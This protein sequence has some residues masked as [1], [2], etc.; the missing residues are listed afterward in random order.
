MA[1]TT[2]ILPTEFRKSGDNTLVNYDFVDIAGQT[3]IISFYGGREASGAAITTNYVLSNVAYYSRPFLTSGTTTQA[4]Y[5]LVS[6]LNFDVRL[7]KAMTVKGKCNINIPW[8]GQGGSTSWDGYVAC[9]L[10]KISGSVN[11]LLGAASGAAVAGASTAEEKYIDA[12]L[13]DLSQTVFKKDDIIRLN[14]TNY[15]RANGG[16]TATMIIAHDPKNRSQAT[17]TAD[18]GITPTILTLQLPVR[19]DL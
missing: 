5:T 6:N 19:I 11:T 17:G 10:R 4:N 18:W 12:F 14:V 3:G 8:S 13:L 15:G 1:I 7:N 2:D 9:E 16:G